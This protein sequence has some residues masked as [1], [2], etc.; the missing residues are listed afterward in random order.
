[1][2][3]DVIEAKAAFAELEP[4]ERAAVEALAERLGVPLDD[5][6]LPAVLQTWKDWG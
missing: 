6:H 4:E 3:L 2:T 1:M 5:E